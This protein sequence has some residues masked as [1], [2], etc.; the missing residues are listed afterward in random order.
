MKNEII[1]LQKSVWVAS[2]PQY[3]LEWATWKANIFLACLN[4]NISAWNA[5]ENPST[6]SSIWKASSGLWTHFK[7][8]LRRVSSTVISLENIIYN[9]K[10]NKF[11]L[12]ILR[13]WELGKEILK[14]ISGKRNGI[15]HA[16]GNRN[17]ELNGT[18]E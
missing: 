12:F 4:M 18:E 3:E 9:G 11:I 8:C 6:Y 1:V 14:R 5:K 17:N 15:L 7:I 2:A 10:L 13:R 16:K